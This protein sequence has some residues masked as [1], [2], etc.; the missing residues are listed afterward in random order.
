VW[1]TQKPV[2]VLR[3]EYLVYCG[4]LVGRHKTEVNTPALLLNIGAV[5]RNIQKMAHFFSDKPCELRPHSKTHKLP[6]IAHK[7]IQAGAIGITC[8]KLYEA[9]VFLESGIKSVLI[10]NQ[11]V[12]ARQIDWLVNLSSLGE[13]IVCVD[14]VDNARQISEAAEHRHRK[15][16]YLLEINVGL[17][18]CGVEPKEKALEMIKRINRFRHLRFRGLM[19]Y[20]GGMFIQSDEEKIKKCQQ[21][22]QL[23]VETKEIIDRAGFPVE[24]VSAGGSN[25]YNLTGVFPGITE[26][27]VGSY[28]TMDYH[29]S[30][31]GL[32]FE[33]AITVLSSIISRPENSRAIMDTG[34]KSLSTDEGLPVCILPGISISNLNEE[35]GHLELE[36]GTPELKVGDTIE[37]IPSHGCTTIPYFNHYFI[38]RSDIVESIVEI[39]TRKTML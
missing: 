18:R 20:E 27:Q 33:Q 38:T 4:D 8:A 25:T 19:G 9:K 22:N 6:L 34:K 5:E 2:T 13:L 31:F 14:S 29:N 10:A 28:V 32:D 26:I 3:G 21:S 11:V 1:H 17:N 37:I 12:G 15:I 36:N 23:L 7:Q 30:C 24:I 39:P 16:D 35:H